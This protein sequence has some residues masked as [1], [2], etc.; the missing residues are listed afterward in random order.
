MFYTNFINNINIICK[1]GNGG[2]GCVHFFRKNKK[3]GKPDGGNGGNGGNII[4]IGNKNLLYLYNFKKKYKAL[5]GKNGMYN[6]KTGKNGLNCFIYVP[7]NTIISYSNNNIKNKIIIKKDKEKKIILLGGKGGK[8]N[9]YYKNSYYQKSK[10]YSLGE[11]GK[12][13]LI[14]LKLKTKIEIGIIGNPNSGKSTLLSKLTSTIPKI[15]NYN[16]TTITP[17]IGIYKNLSKNF[18]IMDT[19]AIIK[20]S[21]YGK[22]IGSKYINFLKYSKILLI[23]IS[24]NNKKDFIKKY[25]IIKKEINYYININKIKKKI[26]I[27]TKLEKINIKKLYNLKKI[28]LK[29]KKKFFI[30]YKNKDIN[31]LKN[32][33]NKYL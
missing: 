26:F 13:L 8:G 22:G 12:T 10:K 16:F 24:V 14:N 2:H 19:P 32:I 9:Y 5:N 7:L 20:N 1:S 29:K 4:F 21:F 18:L 11:K 6:C 33:I 25:L 31:K 30:F 17:N 27:L 23:V 28:L 15:S 3:I